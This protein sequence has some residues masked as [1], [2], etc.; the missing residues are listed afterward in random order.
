MEEVL[1]REL[2]RPQFHFTAQKNW[3]NDPNGLV[4]YG[5]EYHLFFQYNAKGIKWGPNS[6]GHA[7]STD[8]V[9]WKQLPDALEPDDDFGWIWSGSAVV[10]SQNAAGFRSGIEQPIIA[11]YTT[12]DTRTK[13]RKPCVQCIAYSTDRGR[14]FTKYQGNPVIGHVVAENRDPRV[15]WHEP[16][17]MWIMAL[18]LDKN[19]YTLFGS[20]NLKQWSRLGDVHLPGSGECPDFFELPVD[21]NQDRRKWVFW[22]AAGVYRIG[23]FDGKRFTPETE[24]LTCELGPNGYAAQTWS[25][26][27]PTDGRTI[28]I[29]WM[30]G[31]RYPYMPFNQQMSFP[32]ELELRSF[33]EGVRLCRKPVREIDLLHESEHLWEGQS[34]ATGRNFIPETAGQLFDIRAVID[35]R[36]ADAF[37]VYVHGTDL[38]YDARKGSFTYLGREIPTGARQRHLEFRLIVD[39]TSLEIFAQDGRVSASF[40]FLP[41]AWDVPLE[42]YAIGGSVHIASLSIHRIR[43]AWE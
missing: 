26:I 14:T 24:S 40:C 35:P 31:G 37:G 30:R 1:Y 10:D 3:L 33:P 11:I 27:P 17:G 19:D 8:L 34:V 2:L 36:K 42:F 13:P 9:H 7:V 5:G 16:S 12:G 39:R 15:V 28:Q 43:S 21:G 29:S 41:E 32:V 4:W 22:G 6:W 20:R 18:F 38:R 23:S 25:N